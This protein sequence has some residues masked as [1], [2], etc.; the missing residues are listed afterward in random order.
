MKRAIA[1]AE[2]LH[3]RLRRAAARREDEKPERETNMYTREQVFDAYQRFGSIGAVCAETGCPPYVAYKWLKIG[4]VLSAEEGTRYG[5]NGQKQG[6]RAELEFQ[7]L[8]PFAMAAN[9]E[10][11]TNCPAFD[12]DI[13]GTTVDVKF[14]SLCAG[15]YRFMT[16]S[17][18]DKP[19]RPDWYCVFLSAPNSKELVP[20]QYRILVIPDQLV[21]GVKAVQ[22]PPAGGQY[23]DFEIKPD[24][25]ADFFREYL[26]D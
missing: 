2:I 20:G 8:V 10:L 25:L 24:A 6:A 23:W 15:K 17:A 12:F 11:Q 21:S 16:A 7:R 5:T 3:Q 1:T 26:S 19:M 14:S 4:K 22:F 18:Y 9:K 13:N